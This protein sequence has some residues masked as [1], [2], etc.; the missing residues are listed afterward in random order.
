MKENVTEKGKDMGG[1]LTH[2]FKELL[3]L[4]VTST[5]V[6]NDEVLLLSLKFLNSL[7]GYG[8]RIGLCVA[9]VEGYL[10]FCGILF[11]LIEGTCTTQDVG[12]TAQAPSRS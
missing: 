1:Y 9:A 4:F 2:F 5:R 8:G 6:N 11:E 10:C 7:L 12:K 3:L